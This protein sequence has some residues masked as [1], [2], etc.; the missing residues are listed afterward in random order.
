M[1]KTIDTLIQD[2]GDNGHNDSAI[3]LQKL[4]NRRQTIKTTIEALNNELSAID[5]EIA[6]DF[7]GG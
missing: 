5:E 2:L 4:N 6:T 3:L 7:I 1:L